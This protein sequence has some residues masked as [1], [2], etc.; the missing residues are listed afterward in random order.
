M[1]GTLRPAIRR[2][3]RR[4]VEP[5]S[6]PG[7]DRLHPA[8]DDATAPE[9]YARAVA[10][11]LHRP[12]RQWSGDGSLSRRLTTVTLLAATVLAAHAA[13]AARSEVVYVAL[14]ALATAAWLAWTL[15]APDARP[16]YACLVAVAGAGGLLAVASD[17]RDGVAA[18]VLF[19][20]VAA[21]AAAQ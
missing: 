5:G 9:A 8:T 11:R 4:W 12:Q 3:V 18:A 21:G 17:D 1:A 19:G 13:P 15:L 20:A 2:V 10:G 16:T 14:L 6:I 7:G